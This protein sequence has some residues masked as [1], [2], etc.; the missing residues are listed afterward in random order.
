MVACLKP[1]MNFPFPSA[2]IQW[3]KPFSRTLRLSAQLHN[4]LVHHGWVY[5]LQSPNIFRLSHLIKAFK[6]TASIYGEAKIM[7][8][9]FGAPKNRCFTKNSSRLFNFYL[10]IHTG[11]WMRM[12]IAA[13]EVKSPTLHSSKVSLLLPPSY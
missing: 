3:Q 4:S 10:E 2:V 1:N 9:D 6:Y 12:S 5:R 8:G 13:E 7:T 11:R